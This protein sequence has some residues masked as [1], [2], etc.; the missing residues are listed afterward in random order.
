MSRRRITITVDVAR[1]KEAIQIAEVAIA[2]RCTCVFPPFTVPVH[3]AGC[4]AKLHD[5]KLRTLDEL[6]KSLDTRS[7]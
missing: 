1:L 4:F 7:K 3:A 5:T 6:Y 2:L